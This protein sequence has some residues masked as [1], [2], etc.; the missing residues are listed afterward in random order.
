MREIPA[1]RTVIVASPPAA[2]SRAARASVQRASASG[3]VPTPSVIESPTATTACTGRGASTSTP[4][5]SSHDVV[6][7]PSAR[8]AGREPRGLQRHRVLA[9]DVGQ[10]GHGDRHRQRARGGHRDGV[11]HRLRARRDHRRR[12]P[13]ERHGLFRPGLDRG[14]PGSVRPACSRRAPCRRRGRTATRSRRAGAAGPLAAAALRQL[15]PRRRRPTRL[16]R[17]RARAPP[18]R[19]RG[20]PTP[21]RPPA[22]PTRTRWRAAPAPARPRPAAAPPSAACRRPRPPAAPGPAAWRPATPSPSWDR[23]RPPPP[24]AAGRPS[25]ATRPAS[26]PQRRRPP[27]RP[28]PSTGRGRAGT[29]VNGTTA[30]SGRVTMSRTSDS[31]LR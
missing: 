27:R 23:T 9:D 10:R 17:S 6:G 7:V 13:A 25:P 19:P 30:R 15:L 11:A 24:P 14:H 16:R 21:R 1:L 31:R 28:P 18:R 8:A 5:S 26:R 12:P 4:L 3:A 29:C 2:V 20:P 22:A